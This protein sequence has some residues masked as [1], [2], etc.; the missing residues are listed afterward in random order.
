[1]QP[2]SDSGPDLNLASVRVLSP[3]AITHTPGEDTS[4]ETETLER[5]Q[6]RIE[7]EK[8]RVE[9]DSV[10]QDIRQRKAFAPKLYVLTCIWLILVIG[11]VLLQGFSEGHYHLFRLSE[12][13]LIALLG[14][15]TVNVVGLF[16]VVA[17][18]L[19]P[20]NSVSSFRAA[21]TRSDLKSQRDSS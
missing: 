1:M 8:L 5:E 10:R 12:G 15:T 14:T 4:L 11:I 13:V 3:R 17:K 6:L 7:L 19:F 18:Y 9:L 16:Y 2:P 20:E 21:E